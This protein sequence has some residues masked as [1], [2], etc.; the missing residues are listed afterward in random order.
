MCGCGGWG[1]AGGSCVPGRCVEEGGTRRCPPPPH[2]L[3]N[4]RDTPAPIPPTPPQ[5]GT[6]APCP[7]L[8]WLG[9]WWWSWWQ[10]L[11]IRR[12]GS[13]EGGWGG[14]VWVA[15]DGRVLLHGWWVSASP[16]PSLTPLLLPHP[17]Q[18][19][20]RPPARS[21][22]SC[23][24]APARSGCAARIGWTDARSLACARACPP[25]LPAS[26]QFC[27]ICLV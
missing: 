24:R 4:P 20:S 25:C 6:P 17:P 8:R 26:P 11:S 19:P 10:C 21:K 3:P 2:P 5:A 1:G 9:A 27:C 18:P 12:V 14:E 22:V 16:D 23:S 15:S 7:S 13:Q